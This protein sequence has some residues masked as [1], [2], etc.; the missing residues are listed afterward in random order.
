MHIKYAAGAVDC[1][2]GVQSMIFACNAWLTKRNKADF[3]ER[4]GLFSLKN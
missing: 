3:L 2:I 1:L 4:I